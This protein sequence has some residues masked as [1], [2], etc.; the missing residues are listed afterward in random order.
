MAKKKTDEDLEEGGGSTIVESSEKPS[1]DNKAFPHGLEEMQVKLT[2]NSPFHKG[3]EGQVIKVGK[4]VGLKMI[5]N[6]WAEAIAKMFI[7]LLMAFALLAVPAKTQAQTS[8]LTT[9][10]NALSPY[11]AL[12]TVTNTGTGTL[13]SVRVNGPGDN[14]TIVVVCTKISGTVAGTITIQGSLDGTNYKA[15]PTVETQTSITTATALDVA[16]QVFTWRLASSPYL[17]YRV[18]WTGSGTMAASF[19]AK[20]MKH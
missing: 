7:I 16:S 15:I 11:A 1:T 10:K 9:L 5:A 3:R 2:G 14:V 4:S 12:D 13:T 17:Y 19:A 18:S 8:V 20:L 6:D